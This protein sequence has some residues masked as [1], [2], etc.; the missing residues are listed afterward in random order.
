MTKSDN[1]NFQFI[2]A[3]E[4]LDGIIA[5]ASFQHA[6]EDCECR[7]NIADVDHDLTDLRDPAPPKMERDVA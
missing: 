3:R 2:N 1:C 5:A 6:L 7:W 4:V